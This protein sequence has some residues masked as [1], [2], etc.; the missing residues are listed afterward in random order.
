M[1]GR[2]RRPKSGVSSLA[3]SGIEHCLRRT[4]PESSS[5]R[6]AV[7][8]A[9]HSARVCSKRLGFQPF[10]QRLKETLEHQSAAISFEMR[11]DV[12]RAE[13]SDLG[14]G[15]QQHVLGAGAGLPGGAREGHGGPTR[16]LS[17]KSSGAKNFRRL[18]ARRQGDQR[19]T[20][21]KV[22][23]Q[24][25]LPCSGAQ[26]ADGRGSAKN[27]TA[28]DGQNHAFTGR[29]ASEKT[30]DDIARIFKRTKRRVFY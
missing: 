16:E 5:G 6:N 29:Q 15:A 17:A 4:L 22:S 7:F 2:Q 3:A 13:I 30:C 26:N 14:G 24:T 23:V 25:P 12:D 21:V 9:N 10:E 27:N 1:S 20:I 18:P 19:R 8:L 28:S 11:T